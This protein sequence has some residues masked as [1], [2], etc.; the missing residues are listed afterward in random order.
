MM[1]TPEVMRGAITYLSNDMSDDDRSEIL[2]DML[3]DS[4][5]LR[6]DIRIRARLNQMNKIM[7]HL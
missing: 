1:I 4:E 2:N 5:A 7:Y 3:V 6:F